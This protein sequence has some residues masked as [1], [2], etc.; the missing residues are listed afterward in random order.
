MEDIGEAVTDIRC[1]IATGCSDET[2][3]QRILNH[4]SE[5]SQGGITRSEDEVREK[6]AEF[7]RDLEA[8]NKLKP[9]IG[10]DRELNIVAKATIGSVEMHIKL[11]NWV[12]KTDNNE[13]K[14]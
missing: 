14:T 4:I 1:L 3:T 8:L 6:L 12:L 2:V 10:S 13:T 11:L 9:L 5:N 7:E